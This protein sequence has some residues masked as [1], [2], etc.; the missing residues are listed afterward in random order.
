MNKAAT[1]EQRQG[2]RI[3]KVIARAGICSRREAEKLIEQ[4][5]VT[6]DGTTLTTPAVLVTAKNVVKI[7]GERLPVKE[8]LRLWLFHK[9]KGYVTTHKDPQQ[10][11]TVFDLLPKDMPRVISIGR[12]DL[13]TEGLLL[14]TNDGALSRHLELPKNGWIRRYRV[15]VFGKVS[16]AMLEQMQQGITVDGVAYGA[17]DATLDRQQGGNSWLTLSLKEGK[18]REIRK[19]CEYFGLK[20]NRLIRVSYGPFQLG[21]L[22]EGKLKEVSAKVVAEQLG[23]FLEEQ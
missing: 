11:Q 22:Q 6:V 14:L 4:G 21:S 8:P 23:K 3:A 16:P 7:D 19:V 9:P 5:R 15:R 13:N 20:V 12:L 2:E 17:I 18:N 1:S 10:R